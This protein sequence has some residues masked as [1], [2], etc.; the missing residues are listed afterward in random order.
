MP[1]GRPGNIMPGG[2]NDNGLIGFED[3]KRECVVWG[4]EV[5]VGIPGKPERGCLRSPGNPGTPG[6]ARPGMA[7]MGLLFDK[8]A[9]D[10]AVGA[11]DRVGGGDLATGDLGDEHG[12]LEV[13]MVVVTVDVVVTEAPEPAVDTTRLKGA[14]GSS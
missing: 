6:N 3:N 13:V 2:K 1:G 14:E 12:L 11:E 7:G 5:G 4:D 8:A 10:E 9:G